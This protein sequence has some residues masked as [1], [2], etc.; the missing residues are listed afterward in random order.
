MLDMVLS[1]TFY[2]SVINSNLQQSNLV[3]K[4]LPQIYCHINMHST[5]G[6]GSRFVCLCVQIGG[7]TVEDKIIRTWSASNVDR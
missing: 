3:S 1:E 6:M 7:V 2:S 4:K 5:I